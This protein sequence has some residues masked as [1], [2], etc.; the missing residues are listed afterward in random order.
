LAWGELQITE[1]DYDQPGPDTMEWIEIHNNQDAAYPLIGVSLVFYDADSNGI[2]TEY[3]RINLNPPTLL[4]EGGY[5]VI[6]A[7]PSA[8]K[9]L[10]SGED[11]IQNG[12]PDMI[13]IEDFGEVVFNVEYESALTQSVCS[14]T[15]VRTEAADNDSDPGS[16]QLLCGS[17]WRFL[18]ASTPGA[19]TPCTMTDVPLPP[20]GL[21][22]FSWTRAKT[23]FQVKRSGR[24]FGRA[25]VLS[26]SVLQGRYRP[27]SQG[28][29]D[30]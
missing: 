11:A 29:I 19:P 6:G 20:P 21:P 22:A 26:K 13:T 8:V 25:P 7:H 5:M 16:L 27:L 30:D 3:C 9:P 24:R 10:C 15:G 23:L 18:P 12:A 4:V 14:L 17:F 28:G 1:I 2:C